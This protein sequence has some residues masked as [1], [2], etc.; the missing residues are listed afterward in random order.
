MPQT[1]EVVLVL[2]SAVSTTTG[3]A[4]HG[5]SIVVSPLVLRYLEG[6]V[7]LTGGPLSTLQCLK[8]AFRA[9]S[10]PGRQGAPAWSVGVCHHADR[11]PHTH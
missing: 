3:D 10:F 6:L 4:V 5:K 11:G 2:H 7:L 8:G 1:R 9:F